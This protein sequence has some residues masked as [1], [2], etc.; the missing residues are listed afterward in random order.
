MSIVRIA[1]SIDSDGAK[2]PTARSARTLVIVVLTGSAHRRG[3]WL[4]E[5]AREC[6]REHE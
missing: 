2:A 4:L 6:K 1:S 3:L 5:Q